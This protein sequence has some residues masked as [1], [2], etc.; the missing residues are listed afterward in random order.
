MRKVQFRV[1]PHEAKLTLG[2][3]LQR[4]LPAVPRT[5]LK[6]LM[7]QG[8]V[9]LAGRIQQ[10]GRTPLKAGW[11]VLAEVPGN[12]GN[13]PTQ[14]KLQERSLLYQD[15]SVVAIDKPSGVK[16]H[17]NHP[18][19]TTITMVEAAKQLMGDEEIF[20]VHRLDRCTSG[21]LLFARTQAAAKHLG[22]QFA[23]RTVQKQYLAIV[24]GK[25]EAS[26]RIDLPLIRRE[27]FA[28]VDVHEGK[29]SQTR[30]EL[31]SSGPE[32][33][34]VRCWPETGRTHQIRA[35]MTAVNCPL[36]GDVLYDGKLGI[37]LK[38]DP[39]P[40]DLPGAMLHCEALQF[41]S[42][43]AGAVEVKTGFPHRFGSALKRSRIPRVFT[44]SPSEDSVKDLDTSSEV[45][46]RP[47]GRPRRTPLRDRAQ[48]PAR[49]PKRHPRR[50]RGSSKSKRS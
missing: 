49:K 47:P 35:H 13:S 5:K 19:E 44:E 4:R 42:P 12:L 1:L 34:L 46:P 26:G 9:K 15:E 8:K 16:C 45:D 24:E 30:Y 41:H 20:L 27:G 32:H 2:F 3:L 37:K 36:A 25:P 18:Q 38:D 6:W 23:R 48:S 10:D 33:S 22:R 14:F 11:S 40:L 21:V 39:R 31:V 28:Q 50:R 29:S 7:A 17:R 43:K